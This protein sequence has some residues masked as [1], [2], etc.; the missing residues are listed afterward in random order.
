MSS[1]ECKEILAEEFEE[2]TEKQWK[3]IAKYKNTL[4]MDVR[5]FNHPQIGDVWMLG[6]DG[7]YEIHKKYDY[8]M[9]VKKGEITPDS[10]LFS[11][12]QGMTYPGNTDI[13]LTTSKYFEENG[14]ADDRHDLV[15]GLFF[16]KEW[17]AQE[18]QEGVWSV[19]MS[20]EDTINGLLKIGFKRSDSFDALCEG[21]STINKHARN[22]DLSEGP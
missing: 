11:I 3:R 18:E 9:V 20:V 15:P 7:D 6:D 14:Y 2:T 17:K 12:K 10:Y 16:P 19:K 4:G 13:C 22:H 5:Q 8:P 21:I 1:D